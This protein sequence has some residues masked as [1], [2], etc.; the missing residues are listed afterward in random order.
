LTI[1]AK[2]IWKTEQE[3][4]V[5]ADRRRAETKSIRAPL[6]DPNAAP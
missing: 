5:T 4:R 1:R 3:A 2:N 6:M